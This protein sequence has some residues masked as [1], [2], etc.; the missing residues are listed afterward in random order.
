METVKGER[1]NKFA[2]CRRDNDFP[3]AGISKNQMPILKGEREN[4]ENA[5]DKEV[6]IAVKHDAHEVEKVTYNP[7]APTDI[8]MNHMKEDSE[9][10][11]DDKTEGPSL[12]RRCEWV[13]QVRPSGHRVACQGKHKPWDPGIH[14]MISHGMKR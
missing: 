5:P 11:V 12:V 6:A 3:V 10:E 9:K 8:A 7:V 1:E 14:C 2:I 4:K 13:C